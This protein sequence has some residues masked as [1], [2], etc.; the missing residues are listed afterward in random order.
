MGEM[1]RT[2]REI[3]HTGFFTVY[4]EVLVYALRVKGDT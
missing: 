1:Q 2:L 4:C 3:R